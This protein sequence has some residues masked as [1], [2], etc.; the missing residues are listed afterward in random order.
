[1]AMGAKH[2]EYALSSSYK[3]AHPRA[4]RCP[5]TP[6]TPWPRGRESVTLLHRVVE[7]I[8]RLAAR[9]EL[10]Y[11]RDLDQESKVRLD[12]LRRAGDLAPFIREQWRDTVGREL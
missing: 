3:C 2:V 6:L 7:T 4:P 12:H 11:A 1:M 10:L 8:R 5:R 9:G